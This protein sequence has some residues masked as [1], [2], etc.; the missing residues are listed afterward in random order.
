[1]EKK[2]SEI[3]GGDIT[4][5]DGNIA[6]FGTVHSSKRKNRDVIVTGQRVIQHTGKTYCLDGSNGY[7]MEA[8]HVDRCQG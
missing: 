5:Y 1:M 4:T 7:A 2:F 6:F 8:R 3:N